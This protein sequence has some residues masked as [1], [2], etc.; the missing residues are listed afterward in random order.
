MGCFFG[1][2]DFL[3]GFW[4]LRENTKRRPIF[5]IADPHTKFWN[6]FFFTKNE[7]KCLQQKKG[8]NM[9][10][11]WLLGSFKKLHQGLATAKCLRSR[12]LRLNTNQYLLPHHLHSI[13]DVFRLAGTFFGPQNP[14]KYGKMQN[15]LNPF[16]RGF[17]G[18]TLLIGMGCIRSDSCFLPFFDLMLHCLKPSLPRF[19]LQNQSVIFASVLLQ[20]PS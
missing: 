20:N 11:S 6:C 13:G 4:H 7:E 5:R 3:E 9:M 8:C 17:S 19:L 15:G 1:M 2:R 18:Q 10:N 14:E 16:A 12:K